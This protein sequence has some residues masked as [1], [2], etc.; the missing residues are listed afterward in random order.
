MST[1]NIA[2]GTIRSRRGRR[3]RRRRQRRLPIL[4]F[5]L[6]LFC[7]IGTAVFL[8]S[9]LKKSYSIAK[10]YPQ[11][12]DSADLPLMTEDL[13]V[14]DPQ[15]EYDTSVT[16][17]EAGIVLNTTDKTVVYS[18]N[19]YERLYP[20]S[21]TKVMT[22]LLVLENGG[23]DE[24]VEVTKDAVIT[25]NGASLAG[26]KPGDKITVRELLYGLM[27]PSGNDAA[28]ALAVH[29]SGSVDAFVAEMNRKA[30]LL[31]CAGTHFVNTNGLSDDQHYTT[32]Y[33]FCLIFQKAL[34]HP[35]FREIISTRQHV[36]NWIGSDGAGIAKTWDNS[37]WYLT[38]KAA[39]PK[40]VTVIGGKTGT[41]RA[42]GSC[43][44]MAS[45]NEEGKE[46]ISII[47][48]AENHDTLYQNMTNILGKIKE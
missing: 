23:L 48:K 15:E 21:L 29:T 3:R 40:T 27:L 22:A 32:A 38:K 20:A 37:N 6:I 9:G 1:P 2:A 5:L 19:P 35:E 31:G 26:I 34:E 45:E 12:M 42:A 18:K 46:F 25:E 28:N 39:S 47:L 7:L 41:T 10:R 14:I 24:T 33:D 43:L 36:G 30:A 13:A 16:S 11:F 44:V 4:L 8:L 17:S